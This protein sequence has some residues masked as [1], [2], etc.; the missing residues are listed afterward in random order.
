[1]IDHKH[2]FIFIHIIKTGGT[3]IESVLKKMHTEIF[4]HPDKICGNIQTCI[5]RGV[6]NKGNVDFSAKGKT[7]ECVS[8]LGAEAMWMYEREKKSHITAKQYNEFLYNKKLYDIWDSYFKF[9]FVRNPWSYMVSLYT[10]FVHRPYFKRKHKHFRK[11]PPR[12]FCDF[13]KVFANRDEPF[14]PLQDEHMFNQIDWIT[15][16]SGKVI[17]DYIGKL[18]NLQN[19]FDN[20]CNKINI[21]RVKIPRMNSSHRQKLH[22]NF[23]DYYDNKTIDVVGE[24][25]KRDIEYF[26]YTFEK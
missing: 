9:A 23:R 20:I 5:P 2:K 13:V 12:D 24:I 18:E 4:V 8:K 11:K 17:V 1:M 7:A 3:S 16:A 10:M 22:Q 14:C 15:D 6:D 19:D 25:F 26:G 21:S